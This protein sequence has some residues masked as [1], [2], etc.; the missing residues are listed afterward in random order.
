MKRINEIFYSIQG[1]GHYAGT[2]AVFIRFSGCNLKCG[3]CDTDHSSYDLLSIEEIIEKIN[4]FP[5]CRWIILTGGEPSLFIDNKFV[6]K[7]KEATGKKIAIETNGSARVPENIDWITVSP[8]TGFDGVG[9]YEILVDRADE[10]KVVDLGQPLD[11]YF[12]LP[13]V[14]PE[15]IMSLQPCFVEDKIKFKSNTE[16]T[17]KRVL[18]DP[19]WN[20]SLQFHRFLGIR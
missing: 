6:E 5:P 15:T 13:M 3:F 9:E 11:Q 8:K 12:S 2:P 7:L 19:R 18:E 17:L 4:S 10:L 1:E 14:N 20:L 16:R